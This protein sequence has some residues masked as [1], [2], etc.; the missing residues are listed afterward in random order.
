MLLVTCVP[1]AK[2][3][4]TENVVGAPTGTLS[5]GSG[6]VALIGAVGLT[7]GWPKKVS[8]QRWLQTGQNCWLS[9][10]ISQLL[11]GR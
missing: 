3:V 2:R 6:C 1:E 10:R 11:C 5:T 8:A 7:R 4:S 9:D